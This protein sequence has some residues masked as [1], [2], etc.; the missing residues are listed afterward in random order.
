MPIYEYECR[1]CGNTEEFLAKNY[2]EGRAVGYLQCTECAGVCSR[3]MTSANF[4]IT[5]FNAKN[6][7]NLPSYEDVMNPD[8]TAKSEWGKK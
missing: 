3:V 5:G 7:Y 1:N 8:G 6:G 2:D 4:R